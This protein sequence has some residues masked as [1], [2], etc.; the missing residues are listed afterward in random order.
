MTVDKI[1]GGSGKQVLNLILLELSTRLLR[2]RKQLAQATEKLRAGLLLHGSTADQTVNDVGRLVWASSQDENGNIWRQG[3]ATTKGLFI[4]DVVE[5][6]LDAPEIRAKALALF[7]E[8]DSADYD[9]ISH[10]IWLLVSGQQFFACVH[11]AEIDSARIDV[12]AWTAAMARHYPITPNKK[13]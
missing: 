1:R 10:A 4:S 12:D 11:A 13:N 8:A 7:P 9:A 5:R 2:T 3:I 6:L